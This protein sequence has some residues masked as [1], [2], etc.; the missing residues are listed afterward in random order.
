LVAAAQQHAPGLL[1][2][3]ARMRPPAGRGQGQSGVW[4]RSPNGDAIIL[5]GV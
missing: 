2:R 5:Y 4:R 3:R 1:R